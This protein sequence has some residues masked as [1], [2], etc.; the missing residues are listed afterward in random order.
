MLAGAV[1]DYVR[2][3]I[4]GGLSGVGGGVCG[5]KM[6]RAGS[7]MAVFCVRSCVFVNNIVSGRVC[8][9]GAGVSFSTQGVGRQAGV[10]RSSRRSLGWS[11][12]ARPLSSMR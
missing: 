10:G 12:L 6:V 7:V 8:A 11:G 5:R 9:G 1:G 2:V 3:S 4:F